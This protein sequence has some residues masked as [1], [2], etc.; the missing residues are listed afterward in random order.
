VLWASFSKEHGVSDRKRGEPLA[1]VHRPRI[2]KAFKEAMDAGRHIVLYGPPG[3]GKSTVL[4]Q[5]L[6]RSAYTL[7]DIGPDTKIYDIYR[8]FIMDHGV[9][10]ISQAKKTKKGKMSATV[11]WLVS[12]FGGEGE[13]TN[14]STYQYLEVD[15]KNPVDIGRLLERIPTKIGVINNAHLLS[16]SQFY[17]LA[18]NL[19]YFFEGTKI[20]FV[21]CG[22]WIQRDRLQAT[23]PSLNSKVSEIL[24]DGFSKAEFDLYI[25]Q[26]YKLDRRFPKQVL[27]LV[28]EYGEGDTSLVIL[29]LEILARDSEATPDRLITV[30]AAQITLANIASDRGRLTYK[31]L[32]DTITSERRHRCYLSRTLR[33]RPPRKKP[34]S[35]ESVPPVP[36]P[37]PE[38]SAHME[39][40]LAAWTL[41]F[42][43]ANAS[44][45]DNP[46]FELAAIASWLQAH[47]PRDYRKIDPQLLAR[48]LKRL[49]NVDRRLNF[50]RRLFELS[51]DLRELSIVDGM[52]WK[53]LKAQ[54]EEDFSDQFEE[55]LE[56]APVRPFRLRKGRLITE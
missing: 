34:G 33:S 12:K 31:S 1:Y 45:Y 55:E 28:H 29:A 22:N 19:N 54:S 48:Q 13:L 23:F 5:M 51:G 17:A 35:P 18:A 27:D 21:V 47:L 41:L 7:I 44:K 43:V 56:I 49:E 15:L 40:N 32:V 46:A 30:D 52:F 36:A 39:I 4:Q 9:P 25:D 42:I 50:Y 8:L 3:S 14:E 20:Q 11:N 10:I 53:Y 2:E 26:A 6:G 24:V 16:E 38:R 37:Q